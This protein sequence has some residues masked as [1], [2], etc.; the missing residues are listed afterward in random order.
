MSKALT[1]KDLENKTKL[2][3]PLAKLFLKVDRGAGF[4]IHAIVKATP[5]SA[6][7]NPFGDYPI[8]I[9]ETDKE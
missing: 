2:D 4:F 3:S 9:L 7:E 8:V 1:I 5:I 6:D